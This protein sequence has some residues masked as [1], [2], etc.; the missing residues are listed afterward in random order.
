[1][2]EI[3]PEIQARRARRAMSFRPIAED[4][5]ERLVGAAVLAPSC[6]NNQPWR[7]VVVADP[8]RLEALKE[9]L[10]RGNAW[11]RRSPCIVVAVTDRTFDCMLSDRRDYALF[12]VGLAVQNIVLQGTRE[13]LIAHAIAGFT[14]E[15][16]KQVL[17]IP[18]EHLV[19]TLVILGYPGD[20]AALSE[21][22]RITEH[23][24]RTRKPLSEVRMRDRWEGGA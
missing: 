2:A 5:I 22:Q 21:K 24:E 16:V 14:P 6:S 13:G 23:E 9:A 4:V 15:L 11:A 3:V 8:A 10:S 18:A 19:I 17:G 7:F 12:D 1:M 20:E